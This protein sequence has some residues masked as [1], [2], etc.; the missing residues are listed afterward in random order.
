MSCKRT[1]QFYCSTV[2][3]CSVRFW[4]VTRFN[5]YQIYLLPALIVLFKGIRYLCNYYHKARLCWALDSLHFCNWLFLSPIRHHKVL[6]AKDQCAKWFH[7]IQNPLPK[8]EPRLWQRDTH[9]NKQT[10]T[11]RAAHTHTEVKSCTII[12]A[13]NRKLTSLITLYK[14]WGSWCFK[15]NAMAL[16]C[17]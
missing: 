14:G 6:M 16:Y 5:F 1:E 8:K 12:S 7:Y 2:D 15:V 4:K 9:R 13:G 10:H 11:Q 3:F 17:I